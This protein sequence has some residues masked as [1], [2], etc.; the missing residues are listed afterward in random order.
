MNR[1][2]YYD[3]IEEKLHVLA[4]RV[5]TGGKLN[6]LG[7]HMHSENF[8]LHLFDLLY[9]YKLEN[10]NQNNQNVEAIDLIDHENKIVVQVSADNRKSKL[11]SAL[12][13]KI[14]EKYKDYQFKFISIAKRADN[15]RNSSIS[16]PY[17]INFDP[18]RDV[19]DVKKILSDILIKNAEAQK[20]VYQ[21]I[22]S[23][24][25]NEVDSV[26]LDSNLAH[27][28][29]LLSKE[30]WDDENKSENVNSFQIE[31]KI[32]FNELDKARGIIEDYCLYHTRVDSKYSEFDN[33]GSNKSNSVLAAINREY[34]KNKDIEEKDDLFFVVVQAIIGKI[35]D[36]AN[37]NR[38]AIDELELCVDILVVD[39]FV[40]CKIMEN[41]KGYSYAVT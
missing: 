38:M 36:S 34:I 39:A 6:M 16:N 13:K 14:I 8:Y 24:L 18:S 11:E 12:S 41:P 26:K 25:G 30:D 35:I 4:E 1:N 9:G 19:F 21:F 40:R 10:M 5:R 27:I 15:L 22:K 3:Y 31:R 32:E 28:I 29:N 2:L 20:K 17:S 7:L 33:M 37:Y 23:E